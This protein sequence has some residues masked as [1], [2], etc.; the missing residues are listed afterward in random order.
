[1][2]GECRSLDRARVEQVR[3]EMDTVMRTAAQ[4]RGGTVIVS[5]TKEYDGL[6][7]AAD[8]PLLALA[9]DACRDAGA[10]PRR[11]RTGGGSDGNIFAGNGVPTIVLS[12]GMTDV[13]GVDESLRVAD[14]ECVADIVEA[15]LRRAVG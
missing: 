13:H 15:V 4:R 7:F 1:V 10:V 12:T 6:L 3:E 9:E 5:W 11:F 2:T 14:L 8:D